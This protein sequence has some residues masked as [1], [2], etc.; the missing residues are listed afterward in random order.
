MWPNY[1]EDLQEILQ[2]GVRV[3]LLY[4]D[5][6]YICNWLG[7][8]AVSLALN[9][10]NKAEFAAAGYAPLVVDGQEYG[11]VR[12][13]G[14]FSFTRMYDA[15]HAAP[16]YQ[17]KASLEYFRRVLE[18][19]II[20]DG[21]GALTDTYGSNG[22]ANATHTQPFVPLPTTTVPTT[23]DAQATFVPLPTSTG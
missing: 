18:D 8:E 4:G 13:Y 1:M 22:T 20:S 2:Y 12:Q 9:Y 16:H 11:A 17:P 14:N 21:S 3:A 15:G 10:T 23:T 19:L 5:A 6:D 7:G